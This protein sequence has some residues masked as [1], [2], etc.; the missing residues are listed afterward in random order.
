M[1]RG[2]IEFVRR[3]CEVL[4]MT[5]VVIGRIGTASGNAICS[6]RRITKQQT[7]FLTVDAPGSRAAGSQGCDRREG[8]GTQVVIP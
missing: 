4:R 6:L 8:G 1:E 5:L 2:V 7:T 3:E